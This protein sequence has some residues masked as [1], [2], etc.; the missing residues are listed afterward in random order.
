MLSH[1]KQEIS[2]MLDNILELKDNF[3]VFIFDIYGVIWDGKKLI[4]NSAETLAALK[5]AGKKIIIMSNGTETS[6]KIAERYGERGLF[7]ATHYD[8]IVSSG[9][10]AYMVFSQDKRPLKYY[11]FGRPNTVLFADSCYQEVSAPQN[12]DFIYIGV[13]QMLKEGVWHDVLTLE[14]FEE[15]LKHF[16]ELGKTLVCANPDLKA[17][18]KT[19][20]EAVVRQGSIAAYYKQLHGDVVYFGKP[21]PAIFEFALQNENTPKER[22]LM[23]GDTLGTDILGGRDFGIKTAL[24]L[25]GISQEDMLAAGESDIKT[26]AQKQNIIPDYFVRSI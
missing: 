1:I 4:P 12:A 8:D 20:A 25:T 23:V 19:F 11:F 26:F 15:E 6:D 5:A 14:P 18:E 22:I 2:K 24:M 7:G 16:K 3:D 17:H 10:V 9:D 21:Y 13:P